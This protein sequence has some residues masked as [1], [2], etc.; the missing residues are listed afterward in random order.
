MSEGI[1][2][3]RWALLRTPFGELFVVQ[4]NRRIA[5]VVF[6]LNAKDRM[7]GDEHLAGLLVVAPELWEAA[8][9]LLCELDG[10]DSPET[11]VDRLRAVVARAVGKEQWSDVEQDDL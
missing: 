1:S 2:H 4:G 3:R 8:N 6:A 9:R 11:A 5:R 10:P 7:P